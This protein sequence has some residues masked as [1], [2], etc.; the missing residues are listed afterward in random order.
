M[1]RRGSRPVIGDPKAPITFTE[2]AKKADAAVTAGLHA[3]DL[4]GVWTWRGRNGDGGLTAL[5]DF[6]L[7]ALNDRIAYL[8][9]DSDAMQ[10]REVH[11]ALGRFAAFL[12]RRGAD[13]RIIYLPSGDG[14]VKTG[15]DDFLAAEHDRD[16]VLALATDELRPLPGDARSAARRAA[17][18]AKPVRL[19]DAV[20]STSAGCSG[21]PE[22]LYVLWGAIA[23]NRLERRAGLAAAGRCQ[24]R[25]QDG[26]SAR[27]RRA[28]RVRAHQR[29]DRGGAAVGHSAQ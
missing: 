7:I 26:D 28:A 21:D 15:L 18:A 22:P 3:V 27:L 24:R 6:E 12:R 2:G 8:A 14:G 17:P 5:A 23:A 19:P 1:C 20:T 11:Q 29:A 4:V 25:R 16:D 13:V 9:F 10:K